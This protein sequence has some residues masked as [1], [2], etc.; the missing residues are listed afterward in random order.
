[1]DQFLDQSAPRTPNFNPAAEYQEGKSGWVQYLK[2]MNSSAI[3]FADFVY[4]SR[5]QALQGVDE[6]VEDVIA[7]LEE[8]GVINDTYSMCFHLC[9]PKSPRSSC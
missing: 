9:P 5:L 8:K 6:I 7:M 1:M 3:G 2:Q 4:Q